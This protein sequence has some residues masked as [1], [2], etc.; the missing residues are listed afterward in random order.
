M[1]TAA[2]LL[3]CLSL[4]ACRKD[5]DGDGYTSDVDCNDN[6]AEV[7]PDAVEVCNSIDDD[8]DSVV[9]NNA[10]DTWYLD[11]DS[12]GYGDAG[13]STQA[14]DQPS[15]YVSN[16][17]DCN[18]ADDR[19]HPGATE[20]D[21]SDP[22]DYNCDGSVGYTDADKDGF[23]A[24]QD[25]D[26]S[27]GAVNPSAEEVCNGIDDDCDGLVDAQDD[28]V[29]GAA[30]WYIDYDGDSYGSDRF[31]ELACDQPDGFVANADDCDDQRAT[32]YPG[33]PEL[34]DGYD[35]DC[36]DIVDDNAGDISTYYADIDGDGYG[37]AAAP[38][39]ACAAPENY[40]TNSSDC[41]DTNAAVNPAADEVCNGIDDDCDSLIDD[42]DPNALLSSAD[43]WYG[44]D[45]GDGFG[46]YS[47][48]VL[49]CDPPDGYVAVAGDCN[50][51]NAAVNPDATETCDGIDNNCVD[52]V[53]EA[54]A[55]D[56][57]TWYTD[58]DGD[59]Y[60]VETSTTVACTQPIGYSDLFGDCADDDDT[61]FPAAAEI[62]NDGIDNNC[63]G[64]T[65]GCAL[66]LADADI[67]L[68]GESSLDDAGVAVASL[69][70]LNGDGFG[71]FAVGARNNDTAATDAGSA[72][73]LYGPVSAGTT[74]NLAAANV[75]I[76]GADSGDKLGRDLESGGLDVDGDSVPDLLVSA[77]SDEVGASYAGAVYLFSGASLVDGA[78]LSP[79]DAL[80]TVLGRSSYDYLGI[81]VRLADLTGDG[82]ADLVATA[83][84]DDSGL[85]EAGAIYVIS[86]PVTSGTTDLGTGSGWAAR[87]NGESVNDAIGQVLGVGQD[88][89]GDGLD[90]LI[91]GVSKDAAAGSGAGAAYVVLG[92]L[93]GNMSL[94][95]ADAKI[96]AAAPAS[97]LGSS[98]GFL[99]DQDGDGFDDFALG[100]NL[101]DT[102]GSEAGA[103][104]VVYGRSVAADLDGT[105]ISGVADATILASA[106]GDQLGGAL[107]GRGDLDGDGTN[108]LVIGAT[109]AGVATSGAAYVF[110]GPV[111]GSM[112]AADAAGI[113][114]GEAANDAAGST[115]GYVGDINGT[116]SDVIFV[117]ALHNDRSGTDAGAVYLIPTLGL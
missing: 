44:D 77:P 21:C 41:D 17:T 114:G 110:M 92:G 79:S 20:D 55:T 88:F 13:S 112:S 107:N 116:G 91:V 15:G 34:C 89:D 75:V 3:I 51:G 11:A 8:C 24:C 94:G 4:V 47:A 111:A 39:D 10:G 115:V 7:H 2:S 16:D 69:G 36:N 56:A 6:N 82:Q 101:D 86:G 74:A 76:R 95:S 43:V 49:S 98:I 83:T 33:A 48:L 100:A 42:A 70:D 87:I 61:V 104:Y 64:S 53:D 113:L 105:V 66:D 26:D 37:D 57:A 103:A 72:Y 81:Q 29:T 32:S 117:S 40:V 46:N 5:G 68:L 96:L 60:G 27:S 85:S 30:T 78:S 109:G 106:S 84:G 25:C 12:D 31:T 65:A 52:G 19:Y 14:C 71:D 23:P 9:D 67:T 50:D 58:A 1:R 108:D 28:S 54:T 97:A 102:V 63:D 99:G 93:S 35:N 90:D 73:V 62:C 38:L 18:D 45:D 22:N 59:G 80:R